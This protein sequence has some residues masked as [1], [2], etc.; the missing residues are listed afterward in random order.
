MEQAYHLSAGALLY[1]VLKLHKPGI[2]GLPNVMPKLSD[3]DFPAFAQDAE[4]ELMD[5]GCGILSFDGEFA[6]EPDFA[7]LLEGCA[8]CRGVV[9]ASLRRNGVWQKLTLYPA[10]GAVLE[11]AE[12]YTCILRT[13]AQPMDVLLETLAL[14][15]N[16]EKPPFEVLVDTDLLEKRDLEGVMAAG[17]GEAQA[18]M[19]LSALNG[20][21]G[22]AHLSHVEG[23]VRTDELL[24]VY[25]T[26]GIL[27]AEAEYSET[28]EFLRLMPLSRE[29]VSGILRAWSEG[30][31]GQG[32][33]EQ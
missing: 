12:D 9:G 11:R 2:Y 3:K 27:S 13:A 4:L 5:A 23:R 25:G 24:L 21:G 26:E 1:A 20:T 33:A 16:P 19:I 17:C 14:P 10:A 30:D 8:D 29:D 18:S 7:A 6:I 31:A 22:Y 28:Q 15:E 32:R